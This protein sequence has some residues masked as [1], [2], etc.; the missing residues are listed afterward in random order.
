MIVYKGKFYE[1]REITICPNDMATTVTVARQ[2]LAEALYPALRVGEIHAQDVDE[3]IMYY[4]DDNEWA[5]S[6]QELA[7]LLEDL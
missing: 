4:C 2:D 5:L 1:T 6:D 7:R 3:K